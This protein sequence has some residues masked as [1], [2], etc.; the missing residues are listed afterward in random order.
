[1]VSR[2]RRRPARSPHGGRPLVAAKVGPGAMDRADAVDKFTGP[3]TTFPPGHA[4]CGAAG[5]IRR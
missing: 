1:M 3:T 2:L 5:L 4:T